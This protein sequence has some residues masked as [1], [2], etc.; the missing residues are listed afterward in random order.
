MMGGLCSRRK[1]LFGYDGL[2]SWFLLL[3]LEVAKRLGM[4]LFIEAFPD[5]SC[6]NLSTAACTPSILASAAFLYNARALI[7]FCFV[8]P[9]PFSYWIAR[10][11]V[12]IIEPNLF[13]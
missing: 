13:A 6:V 8:T 12:A 2:R 1:V 5:N 9:I 10:Q 7:L 11:N 4:A 3:I